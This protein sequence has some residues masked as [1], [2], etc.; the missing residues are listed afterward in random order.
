MN[1]VTKL[2]LDRVRSH[3]KR[4]ATIAAA[5]VLTAILFMTVMSITVSIA[6]GVSLS[7]MLATGSDVH[8]VIGVSAYSLPPHELEKI[9]AATP[10][11]DF[12]MLVTPL[13]SYT[14]DVSEKT[15]EETKLFAFSNEGCLEHLFID[16]LD[17]RFPENG[18]EI[19]LN[20][21][22]YSALELG[23]EITLHLTKTVEREDGRLV[24]EPYDMTY[25][26]SGFISGYTDRQFPAIAL[27]TPELASD[28]DRYTDLYVNFDSSWNI[29]AKLESLV[30]S[31]EEYHIDGEK[32][33]T[34]I[35][36]AYLTADPLEFI[37]NPANVW[38]VLLSVGVIFAAAFL[39]IYN[40]YR[41]ALTQDLQLL[42]ML[43]VIG[44][45]YRQQK[46]LTELGALIIA[47]A[48]L[49]LGLIG[50][51]FLGWRLLSPLFMAMSGAELPYRF[52]AIIP[53]ATAVLTLFTL[54]FS[55]TR[56]LAKLKKLAPIET[57]DARDS[58]AS[59][60]KYKRSLAS[61]T[62]LRI[63]LA[64][65][66]REPVRLVV[67][68]LSA[69][70]SVLLFV[71]VGA[72]SDMVREVTL[73]Q[74]QVSDCYVRV[75]KNR[76]NGVT[77]T[78][79]FEPPLPEG[80]TEALAEIPLAERVDEYRF[81]KIKVRT[82]S[83]IV[84][85][86][87]RLTATNDPIYTELYGYD[88]IASGEPLDAIVIGVPD[89]YLK[90]VS[91]GFDSNGSSELYGDRTELQ[92]GDFILCSG[93]GY[94]NKIDLREG[95][96]AVSESL[97]KA[98]SVIYSTTHTSPI[99]KLVGTTWSSSGEVMLI[100]PLS[101][102]EAEFDESE[103]FACTV[104]TSDGLEEDL[105]RAIESTLAD[106]ELEFPYFLENSSVMTDYAELYTRMTAVQVVGYS[107]AGMILLIAVL[108]MA[109]SA[110]MSALTRRRELAMLEAVG[111]TSR[112][113]GLELFAENSFVAIIAAL[114]LLLG[115]KPFETLLNSA[116]GAGI[117]L[118]FTMSLAML[119]VI[120]AVCLATSAAA[121]RMIASRSCVERL[122]SE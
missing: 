94:D 52:S 59:H 45:T 102:F 68:A 121:Y 71:M 49:P 111:M 48:A 73:D 119:G 37:K 79:G 42:G 76:G 99:S 40:I 20:R 28:L 106:F 81:A 103:L 38:L 39:L 84:E 112:Q 115:A 32:V 1:V 10:G 16:E 47:A 101:V 109:N 36:N 3:P 91:L 110:F 18:G 63:A 53:L 33:V 82:N 2:A 108:N 113:L 12:A 5:I 96:L 85:A 51:Y 118:D 66:A 62:P 46:R 64:S 69:A 9:V 122:R 30:E 50:G 17:G 114:A 75:Y 100:M 107:L 86:A 54:L 93:A 29:A 77:S 6:Q 19:L 21:D 67:T 65:I 4:S 92:S 35:N 24:G 87:K 74:I 8:A 7:M 98:Y 25:T 55:A 60:K 89:D 80:L 116:F 97:S 72:I 88:K 13:R 14:D 70:L 34:Q 95:E 61:A 83:R 104:E 11:V 120:L 23:D 105:A 90:Y 41:I 44:M 15:R 58:L 57:V 117:T 78:A 56:P 22:R 26:V 43:G 31:L 27:A